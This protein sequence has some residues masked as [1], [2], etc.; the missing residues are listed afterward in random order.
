MADGDSQEMDVDQQ[1]EGEPL[2]GTPT[3]KHDTFFDDDEDLFG[4]WGENQTGGS[5][6]TGAAVA[7]A[8]AGA[9]VAGAGAGLVVPV[10]VLLQRRDKRIT[11]G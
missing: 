7:A 3:Q 4:D 6:S 8:A 10:E 1:G 11:V 5:P 2:S 9:A